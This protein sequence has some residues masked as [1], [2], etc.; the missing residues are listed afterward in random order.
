M[1]EVK[2]AQWKE[3]LTFIETNVV[4]QIPLDAY[5]NTLE[6]HGGWVYAVAF[7]PDG[8]T[9]ASAPADDTVRL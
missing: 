5:Q 9:L 3:R 4:V 2:R 8:K 1:S 6:G 7:S